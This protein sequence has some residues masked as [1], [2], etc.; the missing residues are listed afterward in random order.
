MITK[1]SSNSST[2]DIT[3]AILKSIENVGKTYKELG[4]E[5][6]NVPLYKIKSLVRGLA[7]TGKVSRDERRGNETLVTIVRETHHK[8][9]KDELGNTTGGDS[10]DQVKEA[11]KEYFTERNARMTTEDAVGIFGYDAGAI[12]KA[13]NSLM[14]EG[15]LQVTGRSGSYN[16]FGHSKD[17][18]L[19]PQ[20][21]YWVRT[22][23]KIEK[24][25]F[26]RVPVQMFKGFLSSHV[27]RKNL[28][29]DM[30]SFATYDRYLYCKD[31]VKAV[32]FLGYHWGNDDEFKED[33]SKSNSENR[34]SQGEELA[35][36]IH[37]RSYFYLR[38]CSGDVKTN[39]L[40]KIREDESF[41]NEQ[42]ALYVMYLA[43]GSIQ[44]NRSYAKTTN[45]F[46]LSRMDGNDTK[47]TPEKWSVEIQA[48]A[49]RRKLE[50]LKG[51]VTQYYG[52]SFAIPPGCHGFF[53][54]T[55][56]S[57][58]EL[59][60]AVL[61]GNKK[62]P[63]Q[64]KPKERKPTMKEKFAQ[65]RQ[66]LGI[67]PKSLQQIEDEARQRKQER[68]QPQQPP[69]RQGEDDDRLPF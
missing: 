32:Q 3:T 43:L 23:L 27:R 29:N 58:D 65:A 40:F 46:L 26:A 8:Q 63:G 25:Y 37:T 13:F 39:N 28:I 36:N 1:I 11:I 55:K 2:E 9:V 5:I 44:G 34:V 69:Q 54:S 49:T 56:L 45:D 59:I 38:V 41:S 33:Y 35:K 66:E 6:P 7:E 47:V 24:A 15:W 4:E 53:F 68:Q 16:I 21:G 31:A 22:P 67:N 57:E 42:A 51:L 10:Y 62:E 12:S 52:V 18:K 61:V 30:I 50:R 48:I 60:K 19:L 64:A 17:G 14:R 20:Y